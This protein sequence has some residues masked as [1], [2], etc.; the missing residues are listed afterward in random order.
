MLNIQVLQ[1]PVF[2]NAF[3]KILF[4]QREMFVLSGNLD[5][6]CLI[7]SSIITPEF[8]GNEDQAN[9]IG[10]FKLKNVDSH[11]PFGFRL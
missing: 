6:L 11:K 1:R 2:L 8:I 3:H 10:F 9:D 7:M 5:F 4:N